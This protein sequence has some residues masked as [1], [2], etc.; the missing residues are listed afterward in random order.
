ML[1]IK[2]RFC[3]P[4]KIDF[5]LFAVHLKVQPTYPCLNKVAPKSHAGD[6]L[7]TRRF[8]GEELGADREEKDVKLNHQETSGFFFFSMPQFLSSAKWN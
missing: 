6:W 3:T 4:S 7:G 8:D 1:S 5:S 2:I